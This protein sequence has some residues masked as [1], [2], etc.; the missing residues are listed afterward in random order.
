MQETLQLSIDTLS[1]A[2]ASKG[3][4]LKDF[5]RVLYRSD[6][7]VEKITKG[8]LTVGQVRKFSNKSNVPFGYLFLEKPPS[9]YKPDIEF[10]DFRTT[11]NQQ[12]YSYEFKETLKDIEH[13]Q[14]WYRSYL[15]A[16]NS[17][18]LPFVGKFKTNNSA[19]VKE[20][21]EDIRV[22]LDIHSIKA[23][24][25]DEYFSKLSRACED[26]GVL[27]FKNSVLINNTR[28]HL[29]PDEFRGF[30]ISDKY[31][32]AVF[33]NGA[34]SKNANIFTLI[35]ELAHIW[36]GETGVS[37]TEIKTTNN[38]EAKCNAIAAEV[39]IPIDQFKE[40]WHKID[41]D[42]R[43]K[44][45]KLQKYFRVSELAIARVALTNKLI[46]FD[47]YLEVKKD[48]NDAWNAYKLKNKNKDLILPSIVM[49]RLKN[50]RT[51]ADTVINLVKS[52]KML[53]SEAAVLLNKSAMKIGTI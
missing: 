30:V 24:S 28:R 25:A 1:W 18:P 44:I 23:G 21:A 36:L 27:V 13:K 53:P 52:N 10:V 48:T 17:E 2:A 34:D 39:L 15:I 7:T 42:L 5:A 29:S 32:P 37:D 6:A 46:N 47:L 26:N 38:S 12:P 8:K 4:N 11:T 31:A 43:I 14:R 45:T 22:T 33:I 50:S 40:Q 49:V 3:Y 19:T 16:N 41:T 9:E 20:I 35:H 51:V